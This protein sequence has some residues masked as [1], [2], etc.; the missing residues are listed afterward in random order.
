MAG[1]PPEKQRHPIWEMVRLLVHSK[2]TTWV[3]FRY[4]KSKKNSKFLSF[5]TLISIAGVALGVTAMI[6]VLSVM[7]GF[8]VELKKRLMSS[9]MHILVNPTKDS[10]GFDQG[11]VPI[12]SLGDTDAARAIAKDRRIKSFA[13]VV[14]A[15]AIL[16][17]ERKVSGVILKGL[18]EE[19]LVEF[20]SKVTESEDSKLRASPDG[21]G[22]AQLPGLLVGQ[23]LAFEMG[24]LP[25]DEIT[26]ISPTETEGP[27]ASVPR[28]KKFRVEGIYH[29]GIPEQEL[30]TIFTRDHSVRSFL[31][32]ADIVTQW[33]I[34]L[35]RFDD[36][37]A[38]AREYQKMAPQFQFKDWI[39]LNSHL[40]ASLRLERFAMFISLAFI[41]IVASFNIVTTLTLMV[42]EKKKEISILK[43]M[44][45]KNAEIG[46]IFLAEGLFI[47][48]T[49][50]LSGLLLGFG[51]CF[52]LKRYQF[53][54]LP[55]VYYDRTLPVSF[56][57]QYYLLIGVSALVIVLIASIY[58]S[59]RASRVDP[60][61][62][63][64]YG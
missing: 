20:R 39:Q 7:D 61:L 50:V 58:P 16:R 48:G 40:F 54:S 4:L 29:T 38:V 31:R 19:R 9:D 56:L 11:K 43:A 37:P 1:L 41:I 3:G 18:P 47:G 28:M 35:H 53:I 57:P 42:L 21:V 13:P 2:W 33:E 6:V 27:F 22:E 52:A 55:D 24:L 45:A 44:G 5:I 30:H 60:L 15:E 32:R 23:E 14:Q 8:E 63:I 26:L 36:G 62:G 46:A 12:S 34:T 49:G 25:G 64:R 59:Q 17:A 51:I 10:P